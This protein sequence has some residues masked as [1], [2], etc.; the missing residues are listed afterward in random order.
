MV[1]PSKDWEWEMSNGKTKM[2]VIL[3]DC[4]YAPDLAFT[5]LSVSQIA[6]VTKGVRATLTVLMNSSSLKI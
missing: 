4:I 3:K 2:Q 1:E 5:L 6:K